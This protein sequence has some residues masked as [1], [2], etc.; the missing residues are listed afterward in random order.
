MTMPEAVEKVNGIDVGVINDLV[1]AVEQDPELGQCR[2]RVRNKWVNGG[3][4]RSIVSDF[5]AAREEMEHKQSFELHAD[6][7]PMLAGGDE[8]PNPIEYL[9]SALASCVTTSMIAHA[10][11]RGIQI[12]ELESEVEGDLDMNG[13]L[14]LSDEVPRGYSNIRVNFTV[15]TDETNI[16]KLR[17]LAEFSPVYNTITQGANVEIVINR[18]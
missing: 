17:Q 11:V 14:G 2:F 5:Y 8:W 13:F 16:E 3:H 7:P 12:D 18:K 15:K 4:N 6:E 9:L 1:N 10:A